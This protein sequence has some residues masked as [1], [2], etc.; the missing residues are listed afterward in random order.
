MYRQILV[1]EEDRRFQH[2]FCRSHKTKS[3]KIYELN[4]VTY[5]TASALFLAI[6][7]L[8]QLGKIHSDSFPYSRQ[9]IIRNFYVDDLPTETNFLA[10]TQNLIHC[11]FHTSKMNHQ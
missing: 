6:R 3:L 4:T 1:N 8:R 7:A 11:R 5:G 9:V 10:R 2:I